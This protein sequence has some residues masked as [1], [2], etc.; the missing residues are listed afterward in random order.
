MFVVCVAAVIRIFLFNSINSLV[1]GNE[2]VKIV[3]IFFSLNICFI[4]PCSVFCSII[5]TCIY[6]VALK[7]INI[8]LFYFIKHIL[9]Q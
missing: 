1:L 7:V 2:H 9:V 4:F 8:V 6:I 3:A 5:K